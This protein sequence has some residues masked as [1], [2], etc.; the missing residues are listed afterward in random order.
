ML[1]MTGRT[2]P[3]WPPGSLLTCLKDDCSTPSA[4]PQSRTS[5]AVRALALPAHDILPGQCRCINAC[6][7]ALAHRRCPVFQTKNPGMLSHSG[8]DSHSS[9]VPPALTRR[10][11]QQNA[12]SPY[13][14]LRLT[15]VHVLPYASVRETDLPPDRQNFQ[16]ISSRVFP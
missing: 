4:F 15:R 6:K 7:H 12:S 16:I 8:T 9:A 10:H 1:S 13:P 11:F 2:M 3:A 14:L 5:F